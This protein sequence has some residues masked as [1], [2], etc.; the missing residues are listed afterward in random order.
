M[1]ED[2]QSISDVLAQASAA[3]L[4]LQ[5]STDCEREAVRLEGGR[6]LSSPNIRDLADDIDFLRDQLLKVGGRLQLP[7]AEDCTPK[8]DGQKETITLKERASKLQRMLHDACRRQ[9]ALKDSFTVLQASQASLQ[10]SHDAAARLLSGLEKQ[11]QQLEEDNQVLNSKNAATVAVIISVANEQDQIEQQARLLVER[12]EARIREIDKEMQDC[13]HIWSAQF[14]ELRGQLSEL[15]EQVEILAQ[16]SDVQDM[17]LKEQA[18][19][20][21]Y[22][23]KGN[24]HEEPVVGWADSANAVSPC[25]TAAQDVPPAMIQTSD[26][27][28]TSDEP[29]MTNLASPFEVDQDRGGAAY[30]RGRSAP[31]L[32]ASLHTPSSHHYNTPRRDTS[33]TS[34]DSPRFKAARR[35]NTRGPKHKSATRRPYNIDGIKLAKIKKARGPEHG[36]ATGSPSDSDGEQSGT[37]PLLRKLARQKLVPGT[38][39][40]V[41]DINTDINV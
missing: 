15:H 28:P 12:T 13:A 39:R 7:D 35:K 3:L 10:A 41:Q 37:S 36:S 14:K 17:A 9:E 25:I 4:G 1:Q 21:D 38:G 33:D 31:G 11:I 26:C 40:S 30:E 18:A 23:F 6:R 2:T 32:K 27:A 34:L 5:E 20:V 19:A 24:F 8:D 22:N 16:G 29:F